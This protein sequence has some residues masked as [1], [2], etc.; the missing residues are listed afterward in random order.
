[1]REEKTISN[2]PDQT[3]TKQQR[4]EQNQLPQSF[5]EQVLTIINLLAKYESKT[6]DLQI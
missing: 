5:Q 4:T 3:R 1:M 2:Q 6:P